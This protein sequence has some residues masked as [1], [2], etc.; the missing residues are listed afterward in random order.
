MVNLHTHSEHSTGFD[1]YQTIPEMV[2]RAKELGYP[3]LALT[4]H[5][6]MG[7]ILDF[8]AE[9]EKQGIKPIYGM[10]AYFCANHAVKDKA[11]THHLVLLAMN[12]QGYYNLKKMDSISYTEDYYYYKGRID[13]ALLTKYNEGLIC[14]S[15]CMASIINTENG[16]EWFKWYKDLFGDR[17]YAEIQPLNLIEQ[18]EYN[19]KVITLAKRYD[20]P[21]VVTTDAH[22][23]RKEDLPY[24]KL[25]VGLRGGNVYHDDENYLWSEE[26]IWETWWIPTEVKKE[27][28]ENTHAI[29]ERCNVSLKM[30]GNH[31]P[32]FE[33]D[34]DE[35]QIRDICRKAW[36]EKVP[37]GKYKEYASRFE[38]ELK[39]LKEVGYLNYLLITWDMLN[40][41]HDHDIMT[42]WGRGSVGGSLVAYLMGLHKIDP[43]KFG[44]KFFRF[45]NPYRVSPPDID[46]DVSTRHRGKVIDYLKE[47]Y[48]NVSKI[49]TL[50]RLGDPDKGGVGKSAI[51]RAGQALKIEPSVIDE[52][53][54]QVSSSIDDVLEI[55]SELSKEERE[56]LVDVAK[57]FYGRLEKRGIHASAILI[58]PDEIE[59]YCPLEGCYST[60]T[61]TG[62]RVWIRAAAYDW[63]KLESEFGLLKEDILG[64]NTLDLISDTIESVSK[65]TGELIYIENIPL[66]DAEVYKLYSEGHLDGVFQMESRGMRGT[67]KELGVTC[68]D[69]VAALVALFRP[70]PIDSGMLQQY[71]DGKHGAEIEYP[72]EVMKKVTE[73]TYGVIVYQEEA[74]LIAMQMAGYNLGEADALR[75]VIGRKEL[76]KIDAA[77]HD[78]VTA[79]IKKGH[80][81]EAA[82]AVGEQLKAA[83]RYIFNKCLSG[84]EHIWKHYSGKPLPSIGEMYRIANDKEYARKTGHTALRKKYCRKGYGYG[85]SM[86]DKGIVKNRIVDITYSGTMPVYVLTTENGRQLRC[87]MNHKIPTPNGD[88]LLCQL[89]VGDKVY[90]DGGYDSQSG[91]SY[92][93]YKQKQELNSQKG[94]QGFTHK[95]NGASVLYENHLSLF[96]GMATP[97]E[98]CGKTYGSR[99]ELHHIDHNREN[100]AS[101]NLMWLCNGCHKKVHYSTGRTE[102]DT[103][104]RLVITEAIASIEYECDE[105]TYDVEMQA[106]H[107]NFVTSNG[108]VVCNSHSVEYGLTSYVTAWLKVHYPVHFMCALMN[109]KDKQADILPYLDEC[110]RLGI[111]V[112]P[113]S[114]K[115]GNTLW[116]VEDEN[117]IRVGL[118]YISG[119]GNNLDMASMDVWEDI[120]ATNNKRVTMNLIKAGALDYL[121]KSRGWMLA[122]LEGTQGYLRRR[123]QCMA[124]VRENQEGLDNATDEKTRKKYQRQL[125][126]W[127]AKL[128]EVQ[129][130]EHADE[131]YDGIAG[132]IEVLSFSFKKL[133]KILTGIAKSVSEF[134]DK[135]GKTMARVSFATPYGKKDGLVFASAWK[136]EKYRHR[137]RGI[138]K[139]ITIEQGK[140]YDF[141]IEKGVIVDAREHG[142]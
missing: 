103:K 114:V 12:E 2:G 118:T 77:V 52:I 125:D 63:H 9:C 95:P 20:V 92:N 110:K 84:R 121:G 136:K 10:E 58:T 22:F 104:G 116:E 31:Y 138:V 29:A 30:E 112:L 81:E 41:C 85:F 126:N 113:P 54:K 46:D 98:M 34:D 133:P 96:R 6:T 65:H 51:Q 17:F 80:S 32:K 56:K 83:G 7:G 49:F 40:W 115:C 60:D 86:T 105:D 141:I 37:K 59:N 8:S 38:A 76:T 1:G 55:N 131:G 87:T 57:H 135:K 74:M 142:G 39:T 11:L 134:Q 93:F 100:N 88:K 71:I 94:H 50:N 101:E 28:I 117:K 21:L 124:K 78:F 91:A 23:A 97:C 14:L 26:E 18:Q 4:D 99:F 111:E 33:T 123:E 119:I 72:C 68:F 102:K 16:E 42:G 69:D 73:K 47:K 64:L 27:C 19:A 75:K 106:P 132:E 109:S 35:K 70:G 13:K 90:V 79:A 140:Q 130:L 107:H 62:K 5:G 122:N 45:V 127:Q 44:T 108:I 36:R 53:T 3:A 24:H 128:N 137:D 82:K 139:G 61:S 15:A 66:D 89:H 120:V 129:L 25:W 67:A 48:G 43:I